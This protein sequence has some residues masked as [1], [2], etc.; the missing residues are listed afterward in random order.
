MSMYCNGL[1]RWRRFV[2]QNKRIEKTQLI[3]SRRLNIRMIR[4]NGDGY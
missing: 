4:A 2:L 3:I 1:R